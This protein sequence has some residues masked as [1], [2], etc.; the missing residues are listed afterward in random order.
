MQ[1]VKGAL[2][3]ITHPVNWVLQ[4]GES[5]KNVCVAGLSKQM[6]SIPDYPKVKF[7]K[8]AVGGLQLEA[9]CEHQE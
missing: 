8:S 7:R 3:E 2:G 6:L 4:T 9:T 1:G 5:G